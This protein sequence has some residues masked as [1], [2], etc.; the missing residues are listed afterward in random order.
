MAHKTTHAYKT[1][2]AR[3]LELD[4]HRPEGQGLTPAILWF[5]GGALIMGSRE[6]LPAAG[7]VERLMRAGYALV[8]VDYRLAPEARLAEIVADIEDAYGWVLGRADDLQIDPARVGIMGMSAGGYLTLTAG[9]RVTPTPKAL[10]SFYGYGDITGKWYREPSSFYRTQYPP[11][12]REEAY[13][14]LAGADPAGASRGRPDFYLYCRQNGLWPQLVAGHDPD[15]DAAWFAGYEP[16]R[17]VTSGYPPTLLLHGEQDTDVPYEQAL[18]MADA[19][20]RHGVDHALISNPAWGH[21]FD[22]NPEDTAIGDAFDAVMRFL[23][24]HL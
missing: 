1:A 11:V 8:S 4:I 9:Y 6:S 22:L 12:S 10:V 3:A 18:L 7:L 16:L 19:L 20:R 13:R 21:G 23:T 14:G 17:N 15:A 2:G 5:H 24:S